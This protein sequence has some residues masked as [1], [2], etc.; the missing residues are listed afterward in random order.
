MK[1][2]MFQIRTPTILRGF[3]DPM[4]PLFQRPAMFRSCRSP[5]P[6]SLLSGPYTISYWT[7]E[8]RFSYICIISIVP[9]MKLIRKKLS[10]I[11]P[12]SN[13]NLDSCLQ[14]ASRVGW[15]NFFGIVQVFDPQS[16]KW[17]DAAELKRYT[18]RQLRTRAC[19]S[20][21]PTDLISFGDEQLRRWDITAEVRRPL[22]AL[23]HSDNRLPSS[24]LSWFTW[25]ISASFFRTRC[26]SSYVH[27]CRSFPMTRAS[28][29]RTKRLSRRCLLRFT[30]N[31]FKT[32]F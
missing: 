10:K 13:Q 14:E 27:L 3:I 18:Y 25:C 17:I 1:L 30:S 4:Q 20:E 6:G 24:H 32:C 21:R 7:E 8:N 26:V 29:N 15:I 16:S 31:E 28:T 11:C 9:D 5:T 23:H 22:A 2:E 12:V 19:S